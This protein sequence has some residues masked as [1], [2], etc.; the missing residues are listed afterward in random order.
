MPIAELKNVIKQFNVQSKVLRKTVSRFAAV[1]DVSFFVNPGEIV[2]LVGESGSG[3]TTVG[4]LIVRLLTQ[5][6]GD[7]L[8]DDKPIIGYSRQQLAR[9]TQMIFQDPFTSLN[10]RL[11]IGTILGE[12]IKISNPD[13]Q[14][15]E[16][17]DR[18]KDLLNTVGMPVDI[19]DTYP[20]QF[21]GGQKQRIAV[22]RAIALQPELIVA[23]EPVSHLDASIQSQIIDLFLSLKTKFNLAYLFISHDLLLVGSIA[24]RTL[25]MNKGK[26]VE[27]GI[28]SQIIKSPQDPYTKR[29]VDSIPAI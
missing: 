14:Q 10:P 21:S 16:I 13:I 26:I 3:K 5:D 20:H 29:L 22:A 19:L 9:K 8:I 12:C 15:N 28:S 23:D 18:T 25:V 7:V 2:G 11:S 24:D 4:K 27:Q 1:D 6:K 17:A